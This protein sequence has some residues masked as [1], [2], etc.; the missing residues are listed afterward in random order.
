M[1]RICILFYLFACAATNLIA[2][3]I[4]E[5]E[6]IKAD[7]I[8]WD[9]YEELQSKIWERMDIYPEERDSL[10]AMYKKASEST[11]K[12]NVELAIEYASV[13]SGL[14]RVFMVRN[15]IGKPKLIEIYQT[16]PDSL[17]TS[18]YGSLLKE[19]IDTDQLKVGD[20]YVPFE[21]YLPDSTLYDWSDVKNGKILLIYSGL[22]CMGPEGREIIKQWTQAGWTILDFQVVDNFDKFQETAQLYNLGNINVADFKG[23][24]SPMKILYSAQAA[25]TCYLIEDGIIKIISIGLSEEIIDAMGVKFDF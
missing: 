25:P 16:L 19:Y 12:R 23:E 5:E 17:K 9:N 1:K 14:K 6:Y 15:N 3:D 2:K 20:P 11:H 18:P 8:L 13:P 24:A 10:I 7:K 4:T 21:C 22:G